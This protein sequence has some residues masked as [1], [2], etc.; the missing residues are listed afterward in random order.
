MA[1]R[2]V[3]VKLQANVTDY[4]AKFSAA[5]KATS[6]LAGKVTKASGDT[7]RGIESIGKGMLI[8]GG[9]VAAG[10]ALAEKKAM[11]FDAQMAQVRT[12][13]GKNA[14]QKD[15]ADLRDAA[16]HMGNS[17]GFSATQV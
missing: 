12:L 10:F 9:A 1:D 3:S 2:T 4:M 14:T 8:A 17:I 5:G 15:M 7:R 13:L 16:L 6:E 11:D